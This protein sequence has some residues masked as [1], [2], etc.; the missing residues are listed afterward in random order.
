MAPSSE[1]NHRH[2]EADSYYKIEKD[3]KSFGGGEGPGMQRGWG[4]MPT[5][6]GIVRPRQNAGFTATA[7]KP[8]SPVPV[9]VHNA[10][11]S[12]HRNATHIT[13]VVSRPV[14]LSVP[15]LDSK[16]TNSS[17]IVSSSSTRQ[18]VSSSNEPPNAILIEESIR[19][20]R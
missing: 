8:A 1:S 18:T 17:A 7:P 15:L 2:Q 13:L 19:R 6:R 20:R 9:A 5:K 14:I 3:D 4:A 10:A 11:N 16:G 12:N